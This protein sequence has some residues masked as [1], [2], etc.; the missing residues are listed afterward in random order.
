MKKCLFFYGN[1]NADDQLDG[2][3]SKINLH[4][5][6]IALKDKLFKLGINLLS[7]K[8]L[9]SA[10]PDLE[11]HLNA[12]DNNMNNCPKYTILADSKFIHPNN[13]NINLLKSYKQVFTWDDNLVDLGLATK[14]QMA[15]PL[16]NGLVD[17]YKNRNQLVVL[18][19]SNRSLRGWY[20]KYN[21]YGERVKTIRWFEKNAISDFKLYGKKWNMSGRLPTRI[22]AFIHSIEKKLPF[23]YCP[24][25]SWKGEIL[26]KQEILK[27][28]RFSIV[29]ENVQGLNGYISEKIFDAFVAG[30]VPVYWGA[31]DI[32]K[33]IS[34]E[35]FINR[36]NYKDHLHLFNY[37]KNMTEEKYLNYQNNIK[38]FL[39]NDS[40]DFTCKK[41]AN[42]ISSN[43][44]N[45]LNK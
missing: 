1:N 2:R 13:A 40:I 16:G 21:L 29:Y 3:P 6:W 41:F 42:T 23:K 34:E 31:K 19:G 11:V 9:G 28:S 37:L 12:W 20:P 30:N 25:P 39:I 5:Q 35:C 38:N 14:I 45:S 24:F 10:K 33:Y 4:S 27:S 7:Q 36:N 15:H 26:N 17:G 44:I 22:G 18:F 43:I 8:N 32:K